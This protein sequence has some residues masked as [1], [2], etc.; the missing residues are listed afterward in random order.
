MTR[1]LNIEVSI[2]GG[3]DI[4]EACND[5]VALSAKLGVVVV[6]MFNDVRLMAYPDAYNSTGKQLF[7]SYQ[8][9]LKSEIANPYASSKESLSYGLLE[10]K[11]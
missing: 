11:P 5:L 6:A 9:A 8:R 1:N 7:A 2:F 10:K 3:V 4:Q